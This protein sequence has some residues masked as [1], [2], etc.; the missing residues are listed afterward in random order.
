MH[1]VNYVVQTLTLKMHC[2]TTALLHL[3]PLSAQHL[4]YLNLGLSRLHQKL[5]P[6]HHQAQH[7][8]LTGWSFASMH[9]SNSSSC[10]SSS[11]SSYATPNKLTA[12][13]PSHHIAVSFLVTLP[14]LNHSH[15]ALLS[16]QTLL[17]FQQHQFPVPCSLPALHKGLTRPSSST[18]IGSL[19]ML[20][21]SPR[22]D[23]SVDAPGGPCRECQL[24]SLQV[25]HSLDRSTLR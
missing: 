21:L 6:S 20:R 23:S 17:V 14:Q 5:K 18:P 15:P 4:Q 10:M 24:L 11:S 7:G 16:Q 8:R 3:L 13:K 2:H 9:C 25:I 12:N 19:A 1:E 22:L